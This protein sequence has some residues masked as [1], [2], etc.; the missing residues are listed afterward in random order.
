[1]A[2]YRKVRKL[3]KPQAAYLAGIVDGEGTVTLT[4]NNVYRH[5][6]LTL[7]IS[8]CELPLLTY[9]ASLIG[10]GQIT[11]KR[12]YNPKHSPGYTFQ[13]QSRQAIDVIKVI[14]PFLKT[15]KKKRA[16]FALKHY[17]KLTPRN[18]NYTPAILKRRE[19]FIETF[20]AILPENAKTRRGG[21]LRG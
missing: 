15:Y 14:L 8:N 12:V 11:T 21:S 18:G 10:V 16:V 13:I 17:L 7:T 5:R 4:R 3:S 2:E 20:F 19:H 1:M 6:Y 9:V